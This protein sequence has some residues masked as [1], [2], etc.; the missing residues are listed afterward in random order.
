MCRFVRSCKGDEWVISVDS[1]NGRWAV[2]EQAPR[3]IKKGKGERGGW[4]R[5]IKREGGTGEELRCH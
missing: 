5:E 2:T 1:E 3:R 4:E